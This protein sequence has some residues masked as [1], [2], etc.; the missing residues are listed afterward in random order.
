MD[1]LSLA[2]LGQLGPPGLLAGLV[3]WGVR[4]IMIGRLIPGRT[5]DERIKDLKEAIRAKD[6]TIAERE[7]QIS[8]LMGRAQ[9]PG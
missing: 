9:E 3:V 8:I 7:R 6:E 2:L 4:L 5:H 1:G